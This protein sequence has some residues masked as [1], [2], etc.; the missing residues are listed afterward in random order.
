MVTFATI[1][2]TA[3]RTAKW[4]RL[5][6]LFALFVTAVNLLQATPTSA[7]TGVN[8][9]INYQARL[10]TSTGAVVPDGTY[11]IEFKIY[12]D[13]TGCETSGSSPCSGTL[14]WTETRTG[15]NRVT[16][17]NGYFSV[18]LGSVTPFGSSV[19]WNQDTLWLS[20]NIGGTGTP[21][22]DGEMLP[23]KRL[24]SVPYALNAG[25]LNGLDATKFLQI[26][27]SSVQVDSGTLDSLRL[28][29]TGASGNILNL[30]KNGTSVFVIGNDGKVAIGGGSAT[31]PLDVT[32]DI[33]T[34]TQ[35]RIGGNVICTS[36]GCAPMAGSSN[37]IQ[38][39]NSADQT[40]NFRVSGSGRAGTSFLAPS[41]DTATAA[42][43]VIGGTNATDITVGKNTGTGT[44]TIQGGTGA[45]AIT[46]Q[47]G[48]NGNVNATT[49]GTG[50]INLTAGGEIIAKSSTDR[51]TSFRIQDSTGGDVMTVDTLNNR[52]GINGVIAPASALD[53][54]GAIQQT[55]FET[56][57]TQG[58]DGNK[59]TKLGSCTLDF[60]YEQC[61]S[62]INIIGGHDGTAGH[63]TQATVSVRVKQ[64]NALGGA[65]IVDLQLN[66]VAQVITKDD[67]KTVT[68]QNDAAGT[69][70]E[71]YGR[72]TTI[73]DQWYYTPVMNTGNYGA[74]TWVWTPHSP[75]LAALPA[76]TQ[77]AAGYGDLY[78]N[79]LSA[80]T[81]QGTTAVQAPLLDAI[82]AGA[83]NIGTTNATAINLNKATTVTGGL[84][85]TGGAVSLTS[86]AGITL[87]ATTSTIAK[88]TT[89][90]T[91]AFQIQN[92]AGA[93]L[94]TAD[95]T[96]GRFQIAGPNANGGGS[97][98]NFGDWGN[99]YIGENSTSDTDAM[100]L[101]AEQG[102][103]IETSGGSVLN[104]TSGGAA[105]FKN[106]TNSTT[107]FRINNAASTSIFTVN[108]TN[109]NVTVSASATTYTQRLCHS[110]A[111]GATTGMTLGDCAASG[112]AD[113]AEFYATDGVV[114]PGD[115]VTP[116]SS[117]DYAVKRTD[118][119]RQANASGIVSTNPTA[120]GILG[121]NVT[122]TNRQPVALA[123]RIPLKISLENGDIKTGDLLTSSSDEGAAMKANV[124]DPVV[125]IALEDYTESSPRVSTL[126]SEEETQRSLIHK[127]DLPTYTS[128]PDEWPS[129][130]GKIMAMLR[131][132]GPAGGSLE[133]GQLGQA[134]YSGGVSSS[135]AT[136][137]GLV[138]FNNIAT[139]ND[140]VRFKKNISASEN[141]ANTITLPAGSTTVAVHFSNQH[142]G[143][144]IVTATPTQFING[145]FR[146]TNSTTN[147]FTIELSQPQDHEITFNWLAIDKE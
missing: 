70:V 109:G 61:L 124:G 80:L 44:T 46:L 29:K 146:I 50:A 6:C 8:E 16:V 41:F 77:T 38:N 27:P 51:V 24:S 144:P 122:A 79:A 40:A 119:A 89:N 36:A 59:W 120:D 18:Q 128:N 78:T 135:D 11:N 48:T 15:S 76:G 134:V 84:T 96:N 20:I 19:D 17:K 130:V 133:A 75:F 71:L 125:A 63:N 104:I 65:P 62:T 28:N 58:V 137:N 107:A 21:S 22:W 53:V 73:Y 60:Q 90:N 142:K 127:D 112:Q 114:E 10:L 85:Q 26:A 5:A 14:K 106:N 101:H 98:L 129:R 67:I 93:S 136:F 94:F 68:V 143:T 12:Q 113:I 54:S 121:Y 86:N 47:P 102:Y 115:I 3:C 110:A 74:A 66:G 92:A 35:Y 138:A 132:S 118:A 87:N 111:N 45:G 49:T 43:L 103:N 57:N 117:Q 2:D 123:G 37:Y 116:S 9:Q 55:G 140:D 83:L 139:F 91:T 33:N 1:S 64:Q 25:K 39:Q 30:Q 81:L 72:I 126:V 88:S 42:P 4:L 32:G 34:T 13:G 141:T 99:V 31:S 52:V 56:D 23:F 82:A 97:R 147:G 105:T 95:T 108:T 145:T 69:V 100:V 7:L 131:I